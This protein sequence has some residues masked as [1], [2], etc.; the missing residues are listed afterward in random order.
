MAAKDTG[1]VSTAIH[2]SRLFFSNLAW[3]P[4]TGGKIFDGAERFSSR[5]RT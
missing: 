2:Y 1:R 5:Q 3:E 4:L